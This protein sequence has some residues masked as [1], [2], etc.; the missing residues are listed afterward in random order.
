[1]PRSARQNLRRNNGL[2]LSCQLLTAFGTTTS[3]Y[4]LAILGSHARTETVGTLALQNT[5]LKSSFH[6]TVSYRSKVF[7]NVVKILWFI[8]QRLER[9]IPY[10]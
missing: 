3:Q 1:M 9:V 8:G 5:G 2:E 4:F 6:G 7:I 10:I